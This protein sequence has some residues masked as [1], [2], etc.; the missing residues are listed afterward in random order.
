MDRKGEINIAL[1]GV[2]MPKVS[3]VLPTY[4]GE[5]YLKESVDSVRNQTFQ[6]WEL[7]I[8]DD[9]SSDRTSQL[10][11]QFSREDKRI[12]VIHN[13]PNQK[14]PRSLNIGFDVA[15]GEYLTWTSDDNLFLPSALQR[16]NDYLDENTNVYMVRADISLIGENGEAL[17]EKTEFR[18]ERFPYENGVGA[19]FMYRRAVLTDVGKYDETLFGVEDYDYWLRIYKKYSFI[20]NIHETLY[21]YRLHRNSLSESKKEMV[22]KRRNDFRKHHFDFILMKLAEDA[23]LLT[24]LY[25][26]MDSTEKLTAN[27]KEK[28]GK[29]APWL[30]REIPSHSDIKYVVYGAGKFGKRT[31]ENL[32]GAVCCFADNDDKKHGKTIDGKRV[33]SIQEALSLYPQAVVVVAGDLNIAYDMIRSLNERGIEKYIYCNQFIDIFE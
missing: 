4:N 22:R 3:I 15:G 30:L 12:R 8:V 9:C 7:I 21:K 31:A 25:Y 5:R 19:C 29:L 1:G 11:E 32:G 23:D 20:G 28:L 24:R 14:L 6:D 27:E 26:E 2:K 10:A 17:P 16:M 33:Y 13:N 18:L